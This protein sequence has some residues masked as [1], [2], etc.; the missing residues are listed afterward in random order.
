MNRYIQVDNDGYIISDS[1]LS[2]KVENKNMI[3]VEGDFNSANKKYN[4]NTKEFEAYEHETITVE[5]ISEDDEINAEILL[6]QATIIS[7][8]AEMNETLAEILLNN[9]EV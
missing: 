1:H 5:E 4:F 6:N 3:S 7:K 2:K 8:Q 9:M